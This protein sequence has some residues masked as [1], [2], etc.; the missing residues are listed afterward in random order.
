LK[1]KQFDA[2]IDA[3]WRVASY[4]GLVQGGDAE[5]PDYDASTEPLVTDAEPEVTVEAVFELPAGTHSGHFLHQ[6]FEELD[7]PRASGETLRAVVRDLLERYGG[8]G[9]AR[10]AAREANRDWTPVI[11]ELVTNV[12]DTPLDPA[13]T[14]RLRDLASA[15]RIAELEFHFPISGL[16]PVALRSVLSVSPD[17][18]GSA[19]GLGF[20]PMRGLMRGFIDLVF[21]HDGR[22]Y[23]VDYKSNRLGNRLPAYGRDGMREA[24]RHHRYDLQYLIYTLALHRFLCWRLPD[25]DYGRHFGG[26]YYLFLRGMRPAQGPRYGVWYDR[27]QQGL[28]DGLDRLFGGGRD[29]A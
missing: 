27:P 13:G 18:A 1:P 19:D 9:P 17:H 25:Y 2:A 12:L 7:F 29:A 5:R 22:F 14:L 10:G 20:E 23:I 3:G 24:I 21:R 28:I 8:L 6:V 16:D 11:E 15:D 26:V 4:S